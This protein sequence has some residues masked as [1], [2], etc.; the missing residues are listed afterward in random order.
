MNT[1]AKTETFTCGKCDGRKVVNFGSNRPDM[2]NRWCFDCGGTGKITINRESP[3]QAA[4]RALNVAH[5]LAVRALANKVGTCPDPHAGTAYAK[6]GS[7]N[8]TPVGCIITACHRERG[9]W[10][11]ENPAPGS[12]AAR[13]GPARLAF[14]TEVC[15]IVDAAVATRSI[16]PSQLARLEVLGYE[17][18]ASFED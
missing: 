8:Y 3:S 16:L 15:N 9:E 13:V 10:S 12:M 4:Q 14:W 6:A 5:E 7:R 11:Y 18:R 1:A 17:W 2:V